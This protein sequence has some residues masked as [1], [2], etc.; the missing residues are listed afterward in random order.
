[1]NMFKSITVGLGVLTLSIL[2]D[3]A[4]NPAEASCVP[5]PYLGSTCTTAANFCPRGYSPMDGQ[6]I[7]I[8]S[9]TALFALLG[10]NFGGDGR[11]TFGLP[12]M[13]GRTSAH[14]GSGPGLSTV[15]LGL[16]RGDET[17]V[18]TVSELAH[19]AHTATF[20]PVGS[21]GDVGVSIS[22]STTP[23]PDLKTP[24]TG[25]FIAQSGT[26]IGAA[27]SFSSTAGTTVELGGVTVTGGGSG[28]GIVTVNPTG[29]N[30][31]M[32]I[33]PPQIGMLHCI[34]VSGLFPPRN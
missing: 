10:T 30:A 9:N 20:T 17:V 26:G 3:T 23:A 15:T 8:N 13:R 24:T 4:T 1:M 29:A 34:A 22:A 5:E 14:I 33:I 7:T 31:E 12:D 21:G 27:P 11:N 28:T 16:K 25:S 19:H 18:Q 2:A 6:I 32:D